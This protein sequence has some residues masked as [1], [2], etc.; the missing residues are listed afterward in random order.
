[1]IGL[2]VV[3]ALWR[4]DKRFV[5]RQCELSVMAIFMWIPPTASLAKSSLFGTP[6]GYLLAFMV[7]MAL[8]SIYE[9]L[10]RT[11]GTIVV[12]LLG[13]VLLVSPT[14]R[15]TLGN[16]PGFNW[17]DP[18]A[19]IVTQKWV[20]AMHRFTAV[21]LGN[22]PVYQSGTVYIPNP[23]YYHVPVLWYAFLKVDPTL[24]WSFNSFWEDSDPKHH[25]DYINRTKQDFV[26]VGAHDNG[27]TYSPSLIAGSEA[28]GDAVLAALWKD[29]DYTAIDR[30][31]GPQGGTITIFQ[32][33]V[34]YAGW[35]PMAGLQNGGS[36]K[37]WFS[38]SKIVYVQSYAPTSVPATLVISARG[39]VGQTV[40]VVIN[41]R[42][43]GQIVFGLSSQASFSEDFNLAAGENDIVLKRSSDSTVEFERL[44]VTRKITP[45]S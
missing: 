9:T 15:Y 41:G 4:R 21:I 11:T 14:S 40:E 25:M 44:V 6:F 45:D 42:Q 2:G 10:N 38:T 39:A 24:R 34:A 20:D 8:R 29:P 27:L 23:G 26:I 36:I 43:S 35:H 13:F 12:S 33:S 30:F 3:A 16:T 32:R 22:S 19:H 18:N 1:V 31:Y 5:A 28:A 17:D 37:P 7:V